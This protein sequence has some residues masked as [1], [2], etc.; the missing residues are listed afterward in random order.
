MDVCN[1]TLL[2]HTFRSLMQMPLTLLCH[3]P[4]LDHLT[5]FFCALP[6]SSATL[7]SFTTRPPHSL[8]TGSSSPLDLH[9]LQS[10]VGGVGSAGQSHV[11]LNASMGRLHQ[12]QQQHPGTQSSTKQAH[13][14]PQQFIMQSLLHPSAVAEGA[15]DS[16]PRLTLN[17]NNFSFPAASTTHNGMEG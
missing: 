10:P 2:F 9:W 3:V 7:S 11:K 5:D 17:L 13:L 6:S 4:V 1:H 12:Q 15:M 14:P 16:K 8:H